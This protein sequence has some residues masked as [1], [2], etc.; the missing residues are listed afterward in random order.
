[1]ADTYITLSANRQRNSTTDVLTINK[2]T[3]QL[4]L[5]WQ[6]G[7][8][9]QKGI[10]FVLTLIPIWNPK[11]KRTGSLCHRWFQV[12]KKHLLL[13]SP[14]VQMHVIQSLKTLQ[15]TVRWA[16]IMSFSRATAEVRKMARIPIKK[17]F[18]LHMQPI[19]KHY[20]EHVHRCPRCLKQQNY[21][22]KRRTNN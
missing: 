17:H 1:M 15:E 7:I 14:L 22:L 21:C 6:G 9:N 10:M 19:G 4:M 11:H 8:F 2:K 20:P 5:L 13:I 3:V 18:Q 12:N 16:M